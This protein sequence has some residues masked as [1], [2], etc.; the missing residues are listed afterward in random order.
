M[1]I[2]LYGANFDITDEN[3]CEAR[4]KYL[5]RSSIV[6]ADKFI[7]SEC[8]KCQSLL[9][10][11]QKIPQI[12]GALIINVTQHV[13]YVLQLEGV[14]M[15]AKQYLDSVFNATG[16][17]CQKVCQALIE[18]MDDFVHTSN[19]GEIS[20][21]LTAAA[22]MD[23]QNLW[24][25]Y[26]RAHG[27]NSTTE[28]YTHH[29]LNDAIKNL[30]M[31]SVNRTNF[32]PGKV[33]AEALRDA[34]YE[35][36]IYTAVESQV[37][38]DKNLAAYKNLF[39]K[40]FKAG[41]YRDMSDPNA[42]ERLKADVIGKV[43]ALRLTSEFKFKSHVYY[44]GD[45]SDKCKKKFM[46]AIATYAPI[47]R[48][49]IPLICVDA[50]SF[51]GAEDG[52][53]IS[54]RGIYL[55]SGKEPPIFFHFNEIKTV[56]VA[57]MVSKNISVNGQNLDTGGLSNNDVKRLYVLINKI[58][59]LIAPLHEGDK[60]IAPTKSDIEN[61]T[62][63][64][65]DD[66]N[67][68][69]DS[70]VYFYGTDDKA[71]KKFKGATS[72]YAKLDVDEIPIVLYDGTVFGSADDGFLM[73]SFGIHV[74]N[75]SEKVVFFAHREIRRPEIRNKEVYVSNKKID[76]HGMSTED[77]QRIVDLIRRVRDYFVHF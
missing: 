66:P 10:M 21:K 70:N 46:T 68:K 69:F 40:L 11:T 54:T 60:K 16:S 32:S 26:F 8:D 41:S 25:G 73:T 63:N 39:T 9:E 65:R 30:A 18:R 28:F 62:A 71:A 57:G 7:K 15:N 35:D 47:E 1:K 38:T 48:N 4:G 5:V 53:I 67:F 17:V 64:L 56:T 45:D 77:K 23:L 12:T 34:P 27:F 31:L 33:C 24:L 3:I 2:Y 44:S 58:R 61:L 19:L 37:G 50:T 59:E 22:L 42:L 43:N 13:L 52:A 14:T 6:N 29:K 76:L 36:S 49:E 20:D 74:H 72:S 75:M 55:H 51:G